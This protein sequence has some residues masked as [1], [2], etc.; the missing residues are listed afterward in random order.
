MNYTFTN[1][2]AL[3]ASDL[4]ELLEACRQL[5]HVSS[6][7]RRDIVQFFFGDIENGL[8]EGRKL[9]GTGRF[10]VLAWEAFMEAFS[11]HGYQCDLC[12]KVTEVRE[13]RWRHSADRALSNLD[14]IVKLMLCPT[15]SGR[16]E[17][18][19]SRQFSRDV[20]VPYS[21]D[22][23]QM[24][25]AFVAHEVG[26]E[27]RRILAGRP[28]RK[29]TYAYPQDRTDRADR[30]LDQAGGDA[31][32]GFSLDWRQPEDGPKVSEPIRG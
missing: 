1:S 19:C 12:D 31:A 7:Q 3:S 5:R 26:V 10:F 2:C 23:E 8:R 28:P 11:A 17:S 24:M 29:R 20:R 27:A 15:C 4:W 30:A 21:P 25:L 14:G 18:F 13:D 32:G 22:L 16:F 9:P 6:E